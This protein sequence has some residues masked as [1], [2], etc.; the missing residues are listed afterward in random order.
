MVMVN[1][2]TSFVHIVSF[3]TPS[4]VSMCATQANGHRFDIFRGLNICLP[5]LTCQM[6]PPFVFWHCD[7][8]RK[9]FMSPTCPLLVFLVF[10]LPKR[11][12]SSV[13]VPIF[14]FFGT[15]RLFLVF[16]SKLGLLDVSIKIKRFLKPHVTVILLD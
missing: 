4:V 11:R 16:F 3:F 9:K 5:A 8:F 7:F 12:F 13:K 1:F 2:S 15:F 6:V 10:Q 14:E